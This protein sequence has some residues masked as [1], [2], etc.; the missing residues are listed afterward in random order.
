YVPKADVQGDRRR[1]VLLRQRDGLCAAQGDDPLEARTVGEVEQHSGEGGVVL[2][3]QD[4]GVPRPQAEPVVGYVLRRRG[5]RRGR[6]LLDRIVL[7]AQLVDRLQIPG[8]HVHGEDRALADGAVQLDLAA[9]QVHQLAADGEAEAGT[10]VFAAGGAVRLLKR[11]EDYP[12]LV[13]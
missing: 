1:P 10:A 9:E 11:L 5:R 13:V 3:D 6:R 12:L 8:G 7:D 4:H 2:D